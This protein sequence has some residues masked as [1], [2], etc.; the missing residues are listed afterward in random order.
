MAVNCCGP[1]E[2]LEDEDYG[3]IYT[4]YMNASDKNK[5]VDGWVNA[6]Q[7]GTRHGERGDDR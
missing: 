1:S 5:Y 2:D 4:T 3:V 6:Q 7:R